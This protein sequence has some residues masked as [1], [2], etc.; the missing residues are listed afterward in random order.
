MAGGIFIDKP[1]SFNIKCVIFAVI[2]I[3]FYWL[4]SANTV[5]LMFPVIFIISYVSM[6]WYDFKYDCNDKLYSGIYSPISTTNSIFK[7]QL[8]KIQTSRS[9]KDQEEIY[10]RNVYILHAVAIAPLFIFTS[11]RSYKK[12]G[13]GI[14]L[15]SFMVA[16][17]AEIYHSYRFFNPRDK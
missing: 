12:T 2:V 13:E 10:L 17:I 15:V 8:R 5:Y 3:L 4:I 1:F 14:F 16:L 6:A 7:P 11:W 9:V